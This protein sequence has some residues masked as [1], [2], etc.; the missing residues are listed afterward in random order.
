[1][2][3]THFPKLIALCSNGPQAGKSTAADVL[4]NE[5]GYT[6]VKFAGVLKEMLRP[7]LMA[8]VGD[9][10]IVERMLEGD[11][12]EMPIPGLEGHTSR[13]LLISLG[14]DWGRSLIHPYLWIK[15]ADKVT[16]RVSIGGGRI[17]IDD[18]RF[19]NELEVVCKAGAT[20]VYI[21]RPGH[22]QKGTCEGFIKPSD[23]THVYD[24]ATT[25]E[26]LQWWI[27]TLIE[28]KG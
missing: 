28:K 26:N 11:L 10:A 27:R 8:F 12:K 15:V 2:D 13:S 17:V 5:Y 25:M 23:C 24:N 14:T 20:T 18:V 19:L 1:L 22:T 6:R 7:L 9:A 16:S 21:N 4:V 3:T